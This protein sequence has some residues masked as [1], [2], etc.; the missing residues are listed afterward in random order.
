M[1]MYEVLKGKRITGRHAVYGEGQ[2]FPETE[3]T[4][5]ME[6]A[7]REKKVRIITTEE[8]PA[9]KTSSADSSGGGETPAPGSRGQKK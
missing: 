4:G 6:R 3:A 2:R 7:V 1:T 8:A 9:K 5:D